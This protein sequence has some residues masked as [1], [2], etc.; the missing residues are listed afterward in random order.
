MSMNR[1]ANGI[2]F[3]AFNAHI[4]LNIIWRWGIDFVEFIAQLHEMD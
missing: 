1:Q 2:E 3:N 4:G